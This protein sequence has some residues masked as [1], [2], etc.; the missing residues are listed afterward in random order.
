MDGHGKQITIPLEEPA[1]S[2]AHLERDSQL[3]LGAV[4]PQDL[5][6]VQRVQ[7]PATIRAPQPGDSTD[8]GAFP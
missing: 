1:V 7:P 4:I 2:V 3:T 6:D 8:V 5:V